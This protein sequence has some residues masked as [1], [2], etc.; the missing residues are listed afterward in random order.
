MYFFGN[1]EG[2]MDLSDIHLVVH[3]GVL[4]LCYYWDLGKSRISQK[5]H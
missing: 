3:T 1:I 2:N 5:L 4:A